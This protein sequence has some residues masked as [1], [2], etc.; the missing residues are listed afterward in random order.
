MKPKVK[1]EA[2]MNEC[3]GCLDIGDWN[4]LENNFF[5]SLPTS[6]CQREG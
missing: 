3:F 6:L 4:Y 1:A 5:K 2:E